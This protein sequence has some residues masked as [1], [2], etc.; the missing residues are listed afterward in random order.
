LAS[1]GTAQTV[2][3]GAFQVGTDLTYPP[4]N[5][6]DDRK[7]PAGF[8]VEFMTALS[9][10][11]KLEVRFQDTRFENLIIGVSGNKFDVMASTL[12]VKPERAKQID[13]IPYMKTGVSIAVSSRVVFMEAGRISSIGTPSELREQPE[14]SRVSEFL[15][16]SRH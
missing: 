4:N 15:R 8:D 6:F 14:G 10:A 16:Q 12:D 5:Y 13:F 11:A 9:K 1:Q 2:S 3:Q 7:E